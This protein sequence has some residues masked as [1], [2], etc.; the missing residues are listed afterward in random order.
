[1]DYYLLLKYCRRHCTLL[2]LYGPNRSLTIKIQQQIGRFL[3][4][5]GLKLQEKR[6][7]KQLNFFDWLSNVTNLVVSNVSEHLQNVIQFH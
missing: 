4:C 6:R 3:T 5:F 7:I 1:M 2:P